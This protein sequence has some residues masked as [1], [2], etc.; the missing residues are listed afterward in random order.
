MREDEGVGEGGGKQLLTVNESSSSWPLIIP[1][2]SS[3]KFFANSVRY[4]QLRD[5]G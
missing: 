4:S 2:Q 5:S 3:F 1:D